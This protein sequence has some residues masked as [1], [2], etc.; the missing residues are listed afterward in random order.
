MDSPFKNCSKRELDV[1]FTMLVS[2]AMG[3]DPFETENSLREKGL[4]K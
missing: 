1:V 4:I 3:T 2:S